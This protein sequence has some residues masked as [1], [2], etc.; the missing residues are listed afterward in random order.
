M[1]DGKSIQETAGIVLYHRHSIKSWLQ[2]FFVDFDYEGLI[3]REGRGRKPYLPVTEEERFKI[4]LDEIQD[5]REG[6]SIG[7]KGIQELLADE[8]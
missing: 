7:A 2:S 8:L 5:K 1:Q 3:D 4:K 6:G